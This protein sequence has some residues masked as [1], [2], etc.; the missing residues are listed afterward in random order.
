MGCYGLGITRI[1]AVCIEH[2]STSENIRLPLLIAPYLLSL[3]IPK[4]LLTVIFCCKDATY[5]WL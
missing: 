5:W 4:V 1:I 2:L 3:I